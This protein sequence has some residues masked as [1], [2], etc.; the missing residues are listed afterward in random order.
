MKKAT[1][2]FHR[3]PG[4]LGAFFLCLALP[5]CRDK[6][7][8][9]D[10]SGHK[11]EAPAVKEAPPAPPAA[12]P[13]KAPAPPAPAPA[14]AATDPGSVRFVAYNVEN[15]LTMER[16]ANGKRIASPKP[17]KERQA[18][19]KALLSAKPDILGISEIGNEDDVKDLQKHLADAGMPLPHSHLNRGAD[20]TRSLVILSKFPIGKTA[21]RDNLAYR[22]QGEEFKM[23]RGILDAT[24][25]TPVGAFR[26]LGVH[27]KSKREVDEGDQEEMRRSEAHLLRREVDAI[28]RDDPEARLVVYG[29]FND[30]RN[31][32]TIRTAQ[33]P[34]RSAAALTTIPLKDSRGQFWTHH[35]DYQDVYSR[36]D[37]VMVSP[38]L[39]DLVDRDHSKILDG[40]ETAGASDHRPLLV[41]LKQ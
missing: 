8:T 5:A 30:T 31:S 10:W 27:L 14:A 35:W 33:G 17:E 24:I 12:A 36:I 38:I 32:P 7:Q 40:E 13:T 25:N 41:I 16:Y 18:V 4:L 2:L 11:Q 29:D 1:A 26:F 6:Q 3:A 34:A 22:I 39:R 23:Q 28:L 37:Y 20:D 15:W 9:E 21:A 19:V